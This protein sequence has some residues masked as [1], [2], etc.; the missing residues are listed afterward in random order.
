MT[1][2]KKKTHK[3]RTGFALATLAAGLV[4]AAAVFLRRR[5]IKPA[6]E[7]RKVRG[8]AKE[9]EVILKGETKQAYAEIRQAVVDELAKSKG[10]ISKPIT[11]RT[12]RKVLAIVRKHGHLTA[13][14]LKPLG[15][16][17]AAEWKAI[18]AAARQQKKKPT[19]S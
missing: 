15:E 4:V 8:T 10:A 9:A 2:E 5:G 14:E 12:I 19:R 17:L 7:A 3:A 16:R 18:V 1:N 11:E 13:Q 6:D